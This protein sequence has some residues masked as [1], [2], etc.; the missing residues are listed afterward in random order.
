MVSDLATKKGKK[1]VVTAIS[2]S[3]Q[4][5]YS[6]KLSASKFTKKRTANEVT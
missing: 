2:S 6:N 4:S 1:E 5:S 3:Q